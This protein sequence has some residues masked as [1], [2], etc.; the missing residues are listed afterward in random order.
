MSKT[1]FILLTMVASSILGRDLNS[2]EVLYFET[3]VDAQQSAN[4]GLSTVFVAFPPVDSNTGF[5]V[6]SV[7]RGSH[8]GCGNEANSFRAFSDSR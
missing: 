4:E 5:L 1:I 6:T 7:W 3:L 8:F 2:Q